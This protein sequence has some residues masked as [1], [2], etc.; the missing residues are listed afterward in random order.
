MSRTEH[1]IGKLI[2]VKPQ[3]NESSDDHMIRLLKEVGILERATYYK[4]IKEWFE[5]ESYKKYVVHKEKIYKMVDDKDLA[6]TDDDIALASLNEDGSISYQL[7]WYN[8]GASMNE[9][10]EEA[11]KSI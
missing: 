5:D 3:E 6:E 1:H 11:L 10:F 4:T 8:G 7:K 9:M 2:E